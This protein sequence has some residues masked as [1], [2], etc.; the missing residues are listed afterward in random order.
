MDV[1]LLQ[2]RENKRKKK[3]EKLIRRLEAKGRILKPVEEIS[4]EPA[5]LKTLEYVC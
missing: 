1:N 5:F 4:G 3:L 2:Q